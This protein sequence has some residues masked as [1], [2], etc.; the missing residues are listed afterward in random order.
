M[1]NTN[2]PFGF[3]Q[4]KSLV[5]ASP[6]FALS[7]RKISGSYAT[8][9][10]RGDPVVSEA[11]GYIQQA[12]PG[13]TAI[14]GIFNGCKYFSKSQGKTVW[15][16]Y[17]PAVTTDI[18]GDAEAYIIDDP[19]ALFEVQAGAG[20]VALAD[21]GSNA[22]FAIGTGNTN[23]GQSGAYLDTSTIAQTSTLAFRIKGYLGDTLF[24]AVGPGSDP[25]SAYNIAIVAFNNQDYRQLAGV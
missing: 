5:A 25:T 1:A 14:A 4:V 8:A 6:N 18:S 21:V 13:T 20:S 23:S 24:S 16:A 3:R 19:N 12:A 9:I 17:W 11:T 10:Y 15:S 22:N 7:T 2:A